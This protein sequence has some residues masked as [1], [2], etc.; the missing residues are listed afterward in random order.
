MHQ[1]H[2]HS[3]NDPYTGEQHNQFEPQPHPQVTP[4]PSLTRDQV[5][6]GLAAYPDIL[7]S[8]LVSQV[9]GTNIRNIAG[10]QSQKLDQSQGQGDDGNRDGEFNF[11]PSH[12]RSSMVGSAG[13]SSHYISARRGGLGQ[14]N[15]A[16][17]RQSLQ[18]SEIKGSSR[19]PPII[20]KTTTSMIPTSPR[21]GGYAKRQRLQRQGQHQRTTSAQGQ[22]YQLSATATAAVPV[23]TSFTL[24]RKASS[25][26]SSSNSLTS[27]PSSS[28]ASS[29]GNTP[30]RDADTPSFSYKT[31]RK[32]VMTDKQRLIDGTSGQLSRSTANSMSCA[33]GVDGLDGESDRD[34]SGESNE[35]C[36]R[37]STGDADRESDHQH[38]AKQNPIAH[39][40]RASVRDSTRD[41]A[42]ETK[43]TDLTQVSN[44]KSNIT[45]DFSN[46]HTTNQNAAKKAAKQARQ[47]QQTQRKALAAANPLDV[48]PYT[49]SLQDSSP[50]VKA[51]ELHNK[52]HAT[53]F[54]WYHG[55]CPKK[56]G[57][58][59]KYLHALTS[60]PSYVQ[61]PRGY[62]HGGHGEEGQKCCKRD[63]CPGDW[64][65]DHDF[66]HD[67]DEEEDAKEE[68]RGED[69]QGE[70]DDAED[71]N[72][73]A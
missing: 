13:L 71:V 23:P 8:L 21:A 40:V 61:P 20:S 54:L 64:M 53:C 35:D 6:E 57:K 14:E 56:K 45:K 5:L 3:G 31:A 41:A 10:I 62:V 44:D 11:Q 37:Y 2:E 9:R 15:P 32:S 34:F 38:S 60:P 50:G 55:L 4:M 19:T 36:D 7:A 1:L 58:Y 33:Q 51:S 59:C 46:N 16:Q 30:I 63:W 18:S 27:A 17:I 12:T 73:E 26:T 69:E 29:T 39:A 42:K 43:P 66:N 70:I 49:T 72:E 25:L 68:G 48:I 28:S 65:W 24:K 67:N 47:T 52:I 22:R